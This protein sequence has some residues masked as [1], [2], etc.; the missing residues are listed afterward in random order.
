MEAV[1]EHILVRVPRPATEV[2]GIELPH[3]STMSEHEHG[4]VLSC[5]AEVK[6]VAPGDI[7]HFD[8][9]GVRP[10]EF[11]VGTQK[12][13]LAVI[14]ETMVLAKMDR[15]EALAR[16]LSLDFA[17]AEGEPCEKVGDPTG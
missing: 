16:G 4:E 8:K 5:G 12:E 7:V 9:D 3:G 17:A 14:I 13:I 6:H 15:T 2:K 11:G 10:L 1:G